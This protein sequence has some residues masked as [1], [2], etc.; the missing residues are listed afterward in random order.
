MNNATDKRLL[1]AALL[2]SIMLVWYAKELSRWQASKQASGKPVE[3]VDNRPTQTSLN[4]PAAA[5]ILKNEPNVSLTS[6][7]LVVHVGTETASITSAILRDFK[8]TK[9]DEQ[10]LIKGQAP[11]LATASNVAWEIQEQ[12]PA[13]VSFSGADPGGTIH[14]I[15][16]E[17]DPEHPVIVVRAGVNSSGSSAAKPSIYGTWY[18]SD[19]LSGRQN[20]LE[21]DVLQIENGGKHIIVRAP[22]RSP[23]IISRGTDMAALSERYFCLIVDPVANNAAITL[24]PTGQDS[25]GLRADADTDQFQARVYIGPRDYFNRNQAGFDKAF[26]IGVLGKI[27]LVLLL[28]VKWIAHVTG[29]YGV[30]IVILSLGVTCLTA[31]FTMIGFRSMRKLQ[32]LKPTLDKIMADHKDDP[33]R[34]N[35]AV[36][37]LYKEHKVSPLS[38]CLPL[39]VQMPVFIALFQAISHFTELRGQPFLWISDLSLPDRLF[40]LPY[41]MPVLGSE[42]NLLPVLMAITMAVQTKMSQ[43]STATSTGNST[44]NMMSGPIMPIMF[45]VMFYHFPAGL[46]L[47][48]L[49]NSLTSLAWYRLAK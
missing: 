45:G 29:N 21:A 11:L 32:A 13:R 38:G 14:T 30:A 20:Q 17:L 5:T 34:A 16:Y 36:M 49:T 48:W 39:F 19:S 1:I 26:K 7:S 2:S 27:G 10:L 22:L 41:T 42:I 37:A 18:R 46:V 24:L 12:L 4:Q 25:I 28:F 43:A 15:S 8:G 3:I 35:A 31:P 44:A 23:K 47:Y 6:K 33:K 40:H 9:K